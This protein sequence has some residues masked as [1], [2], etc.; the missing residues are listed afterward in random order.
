MCC[1][2]MSLH[3]GVLTVGKGQEVDYVVEYDKVGRYVLPR[4]YVGASNRSLI[5]DQGGNPLK[6][7]LEGDPRP[8]RIEVVNDATNEIV[9]FDRRKGS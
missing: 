5:F 2:S 8:I 1:G 7:R 4:G 9:A 3:D 6:L